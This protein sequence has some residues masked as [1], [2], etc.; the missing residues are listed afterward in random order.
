MPLVGM[1][2]SSCT[3]AAPVMCSFAPRTVMPC[4]LRS[5][6]RTY[7]SGSS[8]SCALRERSPFASVM[9]SAARRSFARA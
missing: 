7:R 2:T 4:A 5:T 3:S 9:T 6:M 1:T 8:C